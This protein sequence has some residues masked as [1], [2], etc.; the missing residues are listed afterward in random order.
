MNWSIALNG[1]RIEEVTPERIAQGMCCLS[2]DGKILA[3][4]RDIAP[5]KAISGLEWDPDDAMTITYSTSGEDTVTVF[6]GI[7]DE[8]LD[9]D[10]KECLSRIKGCRYLPVM[11]AAL[12]YIREAF[13]RSPKRK[14]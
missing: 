14:E 4:S 10:E 12:Q 9:M 8:F 11:L 5:G 7:L 6:K 13:L 1:Y 2:R 3:T